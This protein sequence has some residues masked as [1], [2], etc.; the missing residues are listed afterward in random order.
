MTG[1]SRQGRARRGSPGEQATS[2]GAAADRPLVVP[3]AAPERL[4]EVDST[5]RYLADLVRRGLADGSPVPVGYAVAADHQSAGR[6]RLARRWVS[7]PGA[8]VLC[9][10]LL[11]PDL[12]PA[13]LHLGAWAVAIAALRACEDVAGVR[14][15]IKWP[16]DLLGD[17]GGHRGPPTERKV[18]GV[19]AE[20]IGSAMVVGIGINTNWPDGW[21]P[22]ESDDEELASLAASATALNRLAGRQ[23]DKEALLGAY[24]RGLGALNDGL[25]SAGGRQAL[26]S[27]YRA[28]CSTIGREVLVQLADES[29]SGRALDVDDDGCLIV[30]TQVC[31][32]TVAAGDVVHLR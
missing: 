11:G 25:S 2:G 30:S 12:A 23:V 19:L 4:V 20:V 26:A 27:S 32:R 3:F 7:P 31:M 8:S 22:S 5:N 9:S 6:G 18:A 21:P 28:N 1:A 10:V 17:T 14:L 24:L 29:F 15:S 16:N 13:R